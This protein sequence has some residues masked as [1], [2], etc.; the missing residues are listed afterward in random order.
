MRDAA[1]RGCREALDATVA[2]L[3][4]AAWDPT[5]APAAAVAE[6]PALEPEATPGHSAEERRVYL[7]E[8]ETCS[9]VTAA[10]IGRDYDI[11]TAGKTP[12]AVVLEMERQTFRPD[13]QQVASEACLHAINGLP[14]RYR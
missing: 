1:S 5:E 12:A 2:L 11:D 13:L 8:Y 10:G 6:S 3:G 9:G 14:A 4:E 7:A